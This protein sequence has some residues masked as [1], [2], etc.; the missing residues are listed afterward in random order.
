[1]QV[2]RR[3]NARWVKGLATLLSTSFTT[4]LVIGHG[5][6]ADPISP[7]V[8]LARSD[9][10]VLKHRLPAVAHGSDKHPDIYLRLSQLFLAH[11][12]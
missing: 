4:G 10:A 1:M 3:L 6:E 2:V 11:V 12:N 7:P 9:A 8:R 5:G